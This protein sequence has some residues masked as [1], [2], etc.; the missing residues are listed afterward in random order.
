MLELKNIHKR[1]HS[2]HR[3]SVIADNLNLALSEDRIIGLVGPSG[4]GKSTIGQ[5]LLGLE[6]P[7]SGVVL[8]DQTDISTM[9]GNL[10]NRYRRAVQMVPQHPD[11]AFN[12]K[13]T[14]GSSLREVF[15][16]HAVC[17]KEEQEDYL[18]ATLNHVRMHRQLLTRY[19]SQLS[20]GELQRFAIARAILTKP[21]FLIL[22]EVTSMLDVSVQASIVRMLAGL[23]EQ[24]L[25][26]YLFIT[27]NLSLARAFCNQVLRLERGQI[28]DVQI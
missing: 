26:G 13:K 20:G 14:I 12:P 21:S 10:R 27:H 6:P 22:D 28:G 15:R 5:I 3:T 7:D 17:K 9:K 4:S 18:A 19:P 11:A 16:F 8:F 2:L 23:R 1:Y 25:M 24:H